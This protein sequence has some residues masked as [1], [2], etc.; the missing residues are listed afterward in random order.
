MTE[1]E[2]EE[3]RTSAPVLVVTVVAVRIAVMAQAAG[4][5]AVRWP[6]L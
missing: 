1:V 3:E 4:W 5:E 6:L 2:T